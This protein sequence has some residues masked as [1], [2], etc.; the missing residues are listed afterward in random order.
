MKAPKFPSF[1]V[2]VFVE[3]VVC[4]QGIRKKILSSNLFTHY[5]DG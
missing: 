5:D 3:V 1:F 4:I 2:V